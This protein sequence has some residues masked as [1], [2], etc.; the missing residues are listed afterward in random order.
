LIIWATGGRSPITDVSEI[1]GHSSPAITA[2]V[3]AHSYAA[4]KRRAV[5]TM[6]RLLRKVKI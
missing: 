1:L 5:A 2:R 6:A 3:Y 4:G